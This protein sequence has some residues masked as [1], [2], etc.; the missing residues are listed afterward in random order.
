M[1]EVEYPSSD[2]MRFE[3]TGFLNMCKV[4]IVKEKD[5]ER[6]GPDEAR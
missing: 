4:K 2:R 1:D 5:Y 3:N 6:K